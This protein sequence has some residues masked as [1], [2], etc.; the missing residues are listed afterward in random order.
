MSI[1][2]IASS[3]L[4]TPFGTF[5]MHGFED[6]ETGKEH[7]AL[8][9]GDIADGKP[10]LA[11]AHSECLTGDALFSMRC[12]CGYQLEEA[13]RAVAE[14]GRG[15]VLYLR[16]EGRGIGLLNKIRAYHLQ[17][18]GA[19]TVEANERLGFGADMRDYSMCRP[20]LEHLGVK[21]IRLMTNNPRKVKA[22]SEAGARVVERVALEVGRNPHNDGYLNT[23]ASKLG[24][25]MTHQ[26]DDPEA[27]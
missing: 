3:K 9:M 21:G 11:R 22:L 24:H 5:T 23:K 8:S 25:M 27:I 10:V 19:D 2:F 6:T 14:A 16:Q 13:L 12:D 15:V 17:D 26:D 20:M 18:Q 1:N 4:P 7:V